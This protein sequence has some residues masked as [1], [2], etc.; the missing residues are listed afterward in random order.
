MRPIAL[1]MPGITIGP[2]VREIPVAHSHWCP[3]H[4]AAMHCYKLAFCSYMTSCLA[5]MPQP[6]FSVLCV[7]HLRVKEGGRGKAG[8]VKSVVVVLGVSAGLRVLVYNISPSSPSLPPSLFSLPPS[9]PP[10]L[11]LGPLP[12]LS[13]SSSIF[14]SLLLFLHSHSIW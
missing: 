13:I 7:Y 11:P 14:L 12:S 6:K 2:I 8:G 4:F 1:E 10:S 5:C 3:G 9:L